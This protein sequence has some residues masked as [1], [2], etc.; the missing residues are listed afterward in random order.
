MAAFNNAANY[1]IGHLSSR[2]STE[3]PFRCIIGISE[4]QRST[5]AGRDKGA[6]AGEDVLGERESTFSGGAPTALIRYKS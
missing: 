5:L 1:M 2:D 3:N 6:A 4:G